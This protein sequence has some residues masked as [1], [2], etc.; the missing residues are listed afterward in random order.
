MIRERWAESTPCAVDKEGANE[1][2]A[3]SRQRD[4]LLWESLDEEQQVSIKNRKGNRAL[5]EPRPPGQN[6]DRIRERG[7]GH[8]VLS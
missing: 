8:A 5:H 1:A 3:G 6:R 4:G 2:E 7:K